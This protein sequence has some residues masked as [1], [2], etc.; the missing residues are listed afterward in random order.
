MN[1]HRQ[2]C[3]RQVPIL[4]CSRIFIIVFAVFYFLLVT[5]FVTSTLW[6]LL[7]SKFFRTCELFRTLVM[8]RRSSYH[9]K[10][11]SYRNMLWKSKK[12]QLVSSEL[13]SLETGT[14]RLISSRNVITTFPLLE[15][16]VSYDDAHGEDILNSELCDIPHDSSIL[17]VENGPLN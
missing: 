12:D 16:G 11:N 10:F 1:W 5:N 2:I 3:M 7:C 15:S 14:S 6:V 17:S 9:W 4:A 8:R 13:Y